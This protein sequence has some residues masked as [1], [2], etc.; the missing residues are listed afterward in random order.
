MD[1]Q[2]KHEQALN[3]S[4]VDNEMKYGE[5]T[6]EE[7][8][9]GV[10]SL[11]TKQ[12][13]NGDKP[14]NV[15][16]S[17]E[18][19]GVHRGNSVEATVDTVDTFDECQG[20]SGNSVDETV[21]NVDNL[22]KVVETENAS[23]K[24]DGGVWWKVLLGLVA[25]VSFLGYCWYATGGGLGKSTDIA[26]SY[27]KDNEL[28]LYDLKN[29]P[30]VV[31]E[32]IS[33][34]GAYNY[35]YSA[36]GATVSEDNEDLF[37]LTGINADGVGVLS[38]KDIKN[39]DGEPIVLGESVAHYINSA[40]GKECAYLVKNGD[41]MD[42]Y[43]YYGGQS[44]LVAEDIL[45]ENG[46]YDLSKDGSYV[47]YKKSNGDKISLYA[48]VVEKDEE[49]TK[50][51]DSV[52]LNLITEKSNM[53]YYLEQQG[54]T[55]Q[56]YEYA[57]GKEPQLVAEQVTYL[58]PMPNGQ[59]VLY[60]AM[61]TDDTSLAQ[62]VEDDITDISQYDQTRQEAIEEIRRKMQEESMDPIFQDSYVLTAAGKKRI[63]DTV[64]SAASLPGENGF[65]VGYSM[66]APAP[67]KLSEINSF[68]EALYTYYSNLM[69]GQ[70]EVFIAD[71]AGNVY[72]LQETNVVPTSVQVSDDGKMVAYFVPDEV[73]GGNVLMV[74]SLYGKK[75]AVEVQKGVEQMGFIQGSTDL[76]YFYDYNGGMGN[77]GL[78]RGDAM[79]LD[80]NTT[81]IYF[82]DDK[83]EVYYLADPNTTTGNGTL[84][85]FDGK[86]KEEIDQ[87]VFSFQYKE[88]G[89]LAYLKNYDFEKGLGDLYYYDGKATH[90]VDSAVT[91]VYMY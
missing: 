91:A 79:E 20:K 83:K 31:N 29:D 17:V 51:S 1:D 43:V 66:E 61:R 84:M 86:N 39:K 59:D 11:G 25:F 45:Q 82:S 24:K 49:P 75:E 9:K 73:T 81:G 22:V 50:L 13:G 26:I 36:W 5:K 42:L 58:E 88:N 80:Q 21:D 18:M 78:Y 16:E 68:D 35:Y 2:R 87:D 85:K 89:K 32:G 6:V 8:K 52:A 76:I 90:M 53:A 72:T 28:Y 77:L 63:H 65:V 56:L 14:E 3:G 41:K 46:A 60:C 37:Y 19:Q 4:H 30:Y 34:G 33:N 23:T 27:A 55:Y 57:L 74:E 10:E 54:D 70:K 47:L 62:L 15:D 69:Y 7:E 64:I 38:Y 12:E 44:R 67:V 48:A 71:K 40:D